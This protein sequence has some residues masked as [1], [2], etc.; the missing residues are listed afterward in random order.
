MLGSSHIRVGARWVPQA[1]MQG[2]RVKKGPARKAEWAPYREAGRTGAS[3]W[4]ES[5]MDE[6]KPRNDRPTCNGR[7]GV[8]GGTLRK[9]FSAGSGPNPGKLSPSDFGQT[10]SWGMGAS[11]WPGGG[12]GP[13]YV[14]QCTSSKQRTKCE[15]KMRHV[16]DGIIDRLR[17]EEGGAVYQFPI[18]NNPGY[19]FS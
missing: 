11:P 15:G 3:P 17:W 19:K 6:G 4:P 8:D 13:G 1:R 18:P 7:V 2:K 5:S 10:T 16:E 14:Q 12:E 9:Q